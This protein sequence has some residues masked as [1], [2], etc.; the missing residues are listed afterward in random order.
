MIDAPKTV[1]EARQNRY[2]VWAGN[3][4]GWSYVEDRCAYSVSTDR[5]YSVQCSRKLGHGPGGLYCKQHAKK[6]EPPK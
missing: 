5:W 4:K 3:P 2:G 1:E 6:V